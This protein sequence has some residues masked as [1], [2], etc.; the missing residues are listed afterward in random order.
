MLLAVEA[1]R[2]WSGDGVTSNSLM[3]GG[4]W[5]SLQRN[6]NSDSLADLRS[7]VP[8]VDAN[9][10]GMKTPAQGAATSV[11]LAT[12]PALEGIGGRYFEDCHEAEISDGIHGVRP[13]ALDPAAATRLWDVSVR[14]LAGIQR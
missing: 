9:G 2:R 5:T 10:Q 3:P 4:I 1:T 8:A 12:S 7:T 6:W 14:L 11:L 13:Y